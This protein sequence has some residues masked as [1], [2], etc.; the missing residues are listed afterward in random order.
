MMTDTY[1]AAF[2]AGPGWDEAAIRL[3]EEETTAFPQVG[4]RDSIYS[5]K[6]VSVQMERYESCFRKIGYG[7][8]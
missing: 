8:A 5:E 6:A 1:F 2:F 4:E 3:Q 7:K